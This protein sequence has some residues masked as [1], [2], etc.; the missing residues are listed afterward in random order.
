MGHI[1]DVDFFSAG[2]TSNILRNPISVTLK[3]IFRTD[4]CVVGNALNKAR[5]MRRPGT[6][7]HGTSSQV[8]FAPKQ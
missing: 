8:T 4:V 5:D 2:V 1:A 7:Y 6:K 3:K